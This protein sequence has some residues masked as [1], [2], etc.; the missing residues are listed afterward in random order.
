[1]YFGEVLPKSPGRLP[2]DGR[3]PGEPRKMSTKRIAAAT[4]MIARTRPGGQ[5][6]ALP[7]GTAGEGIA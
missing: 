4:P 2:A 3:G 1:M 7:A 6:R 5:R